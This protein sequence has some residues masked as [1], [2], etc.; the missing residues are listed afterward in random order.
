MKEIPKFK[1]NDIVE[2]VKKEYGHGFEIGDQVVIVAI[3]YNEDGRIDDYKC[4]LD[5]EDWYLKDEELKPL[6]NHKIGCNDKFFKIFG[7]ELGK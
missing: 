6:P 5:K 2:V 4:V 3:N 1:I 7:G